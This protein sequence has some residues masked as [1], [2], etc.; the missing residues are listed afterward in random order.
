MKEEMTTKEPLLRIVRVPGVH[1]KKKLLVYVTGIV[2]ALLCSALFI[3][4]VTGLN[5]LAVYKAMLEGAFG[6]TSLSATLRRTSITL[7]DTMFL[8]LIAVGLAPAFKMRFWNIGAEG[9]V[10]IGGIVSAGLMLK[11]SDKIPSCV[12]LLLMFVTSAVCGA[13]WGFLP[14]L[15]KAR[16]NTNETLFT[17]MMNYVAIQMT[18]FCVSLWENPFGSNSVGIINQNTMAGWL[19]PIGSQAYGWNVILTITITVLVY[20]YMKKSR[21]GYEIAVVG[22]SHN[23]ARYAGIPVKKVILRTMLLS[24]AIC[25]IAGF[26][27]VSGIDHT[28]SVNTCGGKGFTAIIVA[29]LARFNTFTMIA[30]SLLLTFLERG[31][32]EI[33]SQ[34]GLNE[35][36]SNVVSG[37][38]LFFIL[39]CD[40]FCNYK[41]VINR[42]KTG[43]E[44]K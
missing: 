25:G 33:A 6:L 38:I 16:Q 20:I 40:F 11:L 29:W 36:A 28:I 4:F 8:L 14:A 9:Q 23:T 10:L 21:H 7:R 12:L 22:E 31:A 41:V 43:K 5:P 3:Y 1:V 30:I 39:G 26:M 13:L 34:F 44:A 18:A 15:F 35:H 17:L 42:K 24:G 37:M 19:P 2:L 32:S 27:G